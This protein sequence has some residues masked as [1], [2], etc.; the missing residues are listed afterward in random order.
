MTR[1]FIH[2]LTLC[3]LLTAEQADTTPHTVQTAVLSAH[4]IAGAHGLDPAELLAIAWVESRFIP[5]PC[6]SDDRGC[7]I[8]QQVPAMSGRLSDACW[9]R[10]EYVCGWRDGVPM[11]RAELEYIP[12]ATQAAARLLRYLK[13]RTPDYVRAYNAGLAGAAMGRGA[14]YAERVERIRRALNGDRP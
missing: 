9:H 13:A 1:L 7:G 5:R 10:R 11:E 2:L 12:R 3:R 8:Y 6:D 4:T 14:G